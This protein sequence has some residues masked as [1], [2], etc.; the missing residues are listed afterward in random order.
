MNVKP[1]RIERYWIFILLNL[2]CLIAI[3]IISWWITGSWTTCVIV[4]FVDL[5]LLILMNFFTNYINNDYKFLESIVETNL[6]VK[7]HNLRLDNMDKEI[8]DVKGKLQAGGG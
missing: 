8:K 6:K 3:G 1:F 5:Y 2:L 4:I 7:Q